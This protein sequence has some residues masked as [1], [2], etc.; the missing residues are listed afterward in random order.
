[1]N[2]NIFH[3]KSTIL[4]TLIMS[5]YS[6][7]LPTLSTSAQIDQN[8]VSLPKEIRTILQSE[9]P[10]DYP[11][12][13]FHCVEN[14]SLSEHYILF[15][16]VTGHSD[17]DLE[18]DLKFYEV[19]PATFEIKDNEIISET[20]FLGGAPNWTFA[21]NK[22]TKELYLL[23]GFNDPI[24]GFNQLMKK[25]NLDVSNEEVCLDLFD[26][27]LL[28]ACG[29]AF[30]ESVILDDLHLQS[31]ALQDFCLT[32]SRSQKRKKFDS[33]WRK[34]PGALIQKL[35]PLKPTFKDGNYEIRFF[36][37]QQKKV[38]EE[39]ITMNRSGMISTHKSTLIYPQKDKLPQD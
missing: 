29:R 19:T 21:C 39:S 7:Y 25:H 37:Y 3:T 28:F 36:R 27:Y 31:L 26:T 1:M 4:F 16:K 35:Q 20:V 24:I 12:M 15:Q 30:R 8:N 5:F 9:Y 13:A 38:L 18:L 17:K 22:K 10:P 11:Q 33:W 2:Q 14:P 32:Y 6:F 23:S 34:I